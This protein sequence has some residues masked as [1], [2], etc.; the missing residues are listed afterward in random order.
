MILLV[1]RLPIIIEEISKMI[2]TLKQ[3]FSI[4]V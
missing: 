2:D 3:T 4:V 1:Q